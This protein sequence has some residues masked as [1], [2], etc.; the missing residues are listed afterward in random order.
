[1]QDRVRVAVAVEADVVAE[2]SAGGNIFRIRLMAGN[3]QGEIFFKFKVTNADGRCLSVTILR[4][5]ND[6]C[7]GCIGAT[8]SID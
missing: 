3:S 8:R 1:L 4:L 5:H 2:T 6:T 7:E